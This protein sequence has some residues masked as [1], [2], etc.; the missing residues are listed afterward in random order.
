A[1]YIGR[2]V[3]TTLANLGYDVGGKDNS[4]NDKAVAAIKTFQK[5]H[6]L[7]ADGRISP[8][9]LA[10]LLASRFEASNASKT[11]NSAGSARKL[12]LYAS[13]SGFYV[14]AAGDIIT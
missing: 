9:L 11:T 3:K 4:I 2:T 12:K 1:G 7:T 14:S 8:D 10:A 5:D 6:G 13:G